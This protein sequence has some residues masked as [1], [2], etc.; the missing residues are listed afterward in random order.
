MKK[1]VQQDRVEVY[2]KEVYRDDDELQLPKSGFKKR[3]K[4]TV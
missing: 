4:K 1:R 3:Q 2:K